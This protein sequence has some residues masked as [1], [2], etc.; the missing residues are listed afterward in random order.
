ME[1]LERKIDQEAIKKRMDA[2][3]VT[4]ILGPRQCGKTTLAQMFNYNVFF[5]LEDPRDQRKLE[6]PQLAL[7]DAVGLIVIDE[8]QM[9]PNLF[10]LI[11]VLVDRH[12][13]KK[14]LIFGSASRDLIRQSSETLAG[15]IAYY[16]LG[17]FSFA[18]VGSDVWKTLWFRGGFPGSFQAKDGEISG[19][20][21]EN[22]IATFLERDIPQLGISIP[23][24]TLRRFWTMLSHYHGQVM[25]YSELARSFGI[26]DMTVRNYL[27]IL[28]GTFMVRVL[29]PWY[30]NVGKRLV[31]KPKI[32]LRDS[33]LFHSLM[34]IEDFNQLTGNPKLGASWEGFALECVARLL[35]KSDNDLYYWKVHSGSEVDLFW[36]QA[37]RN[38]GVEFKYN[39]APRL[40]KSMNIVM[41]DLE[42]EHLWII[43][44][45]TDTYRLAEN[46]TVIPLIDI[47][48]NFRKSMLIS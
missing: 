6:N 43:Y 32:Y 9:Q 48:E 7:E 18:D 13:D 23:A 44:P 15:R 4:A 2:F 31:K 33:G 27:D 45:G 20:W 12:P 25:N 46:I 17:G 39:D 21:R 10:P 41:K 16:A 38:W 40:S 3:P 34:N 35:K 28:E 19:I 11:R 14:F 24:Q 8:I 36:Q 1:L 26:S 22:Y 42:L 30:S 29:Q 5:D 37:G 47:E